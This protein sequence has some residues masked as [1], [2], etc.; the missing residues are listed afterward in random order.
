MFQQYSNFNVCIPVGIGVRKL[1]NKKWSVGG[2][3]SFRKTFT[4]YLDDVSGSYY[5]KAKLKA[6]YGPS[7]ALLSD[8]SLGDV[9]GQTNTGFQRG[10]IKYKDAYMFLNVT[11]SYKIPSKRRTRSKF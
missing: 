2:E 6:A 11:A 9:A 4:D 10:N 7:S 5:D 1:I 8:P 3:L